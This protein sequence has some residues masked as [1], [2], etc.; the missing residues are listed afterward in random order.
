MATPSVTPFSHGGKK[1]EVRAHTVQN[2]FVVRVALD[3]REFG[4]RYGVTFETDADF[5]L[6]SGRDAVKELISVARNDVER[7]HIAPQ[8]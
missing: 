7:G 5:K 6:Y 8:G 4:P 3:G 1:Y 2:G